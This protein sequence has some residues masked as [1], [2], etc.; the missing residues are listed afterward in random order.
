[1]VVRAWGRPAI[2][3]MRSSMVCSGGGCASSGSWTTPAWRRPDRRWT[4]WRWISVASPLTRAVLRRAGMPM[5]TAVKTLDAIHLASALL[6]QERRGE[7]LVFVTHDGQQAT[8]A[9]ALGFDCLGV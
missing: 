6:F 1:M 2:S 5:A 7:G 4:G 9:R 8:A 3:F